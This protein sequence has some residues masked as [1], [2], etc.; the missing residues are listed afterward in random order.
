MA[1][2]SLGTD[3][4]RSIGSVGRSTGAERSRRPWLSS[5]AKTGRGPLLLPVVLPQ[6]RSPHF[7]Q[8]PPQKQNQ[9][10]QQPLEHQR[11]SSQQLHQKQP[12]SSRLVLPPLTPIR[13]PLPPSIARTVPGIECPLKEDTNRRKSACPSDEK[14]GLM[15]YETLSDHDDGND[16]MMPSPM[17]GRQ[18]QRGSVSTNHRSRHSTAGGGASL[19]ASDPMSFVRLFSSSASSTSSLNNTQGVN[20]LTRFPSSPH[21]EDQSSPD[22]FSSSDSRTKSFSDFG[23]CEKQRR[24]RLGREY[25]GRVMVACIL[26]GHGYVDEAQELTEPYWSSGEGPQQRFALAM[27]VRALIIRRRQL[28]DGRGDADN[29]FFA[30][31]PHFDEDRQIS[32]SISSTLKERIR[33]ELGRLARLQFGENCGRSIKT[34]RKQQQQLLPSWVQ[35][36]ARSP[37][38]QVTQLASHLDWEPQDLTDLCHQLS[39]STTPTSSWTCRRRS[40]S[41]EESKGVFATSAQSAS[42]TSTDTATTASSSSSASTSS[43]SS[44]STCSRRFH[45]AA[46]QH[47][48]TSRSHNLQQNPDQMLRLFAERAARAEL[49]IV[50]GHA[51]ESAGYD[52]SPVWL[53]L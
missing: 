48:N 32:Y 6:E 8:D 42:S 40:F 52:A 4:T 30:L 21:L 27:H 33:T 13:R 15:F 51:V 39:D 19:I 9:L 34:N 18:H 41:H 12:Q 49:L 1:S 43:G 7:D 22:F 53:V 26:L 14:P 29:N 31:S 37:P 16:W 47:H 23:D 20:R 10:V 36:L 50:L 2:I 5:K 44:N 25:T 28:E 3:T 38:S 35:E 46:S 11:R 45:G 17:Q 24:L